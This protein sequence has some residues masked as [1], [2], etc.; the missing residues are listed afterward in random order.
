MDIQETNDTA[1]VNETI[2]TDTSPVY[3]P[4]EDLTR[5]YGYLQ[6]ATIQMFEFFKKVESLVDKHFSNKDHI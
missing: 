4:F 2:T 5:T 6:L 1:L 3:S